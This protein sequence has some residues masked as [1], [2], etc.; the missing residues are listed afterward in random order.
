MY[1]GVKTELVLFTIK[2]EMEPSTKHQ[3]SSLISKLFYSCEME[4]ILGVY[5]TPSIITPPHRGGLSVP[6][7]TDKPLLL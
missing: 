5:T 6:S 2:N 3:I 4:I 7:K 1:G